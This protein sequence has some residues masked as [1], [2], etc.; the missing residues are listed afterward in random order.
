[1]HTNKHKLFQFHARLHFDRAVKRKGLLI[2]LHIY[3]IHDDGSLKQTKTQIIDAAI[4]LFSM[5]ILLDNSV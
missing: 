4:Y 5:L 2:K 3:M 1:M